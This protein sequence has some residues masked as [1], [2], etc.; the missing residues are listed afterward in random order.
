MVN[1][2]NRARDVR[3]LINMHGMEKGMRMSVERLAED[4]EMLRQEMKQVI[5]T[6]DKMAD[7][8]ADIAT[9]GAKLRGEWAL[10]RQAMHPNNEA[11]RI[12]RKTTTTI[13]HVIAQAAAA[14]EDTLRDGSPPTSRVVESAHAKPSPHSETSSQRTK[15][16]EI[17]HNDH[18][19]N[20]RHITTVG[21]LLHT[22]RSQ[23]VPTLGHY[24][25]YNG[26]TSH[27]RRRACVS[28][29]SWPRYA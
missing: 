3:H 10:V 21:R 26:Q 13:E 23:H 4:N 11:S 15:Q 9:V 8:V 2:V 28:S 27:C 22:H 17:L 29:R 5:A 7:I 12:Y 24:T 20:N 14:L 19:T 18:Q 16:S 1:Y 25:Q 6:V